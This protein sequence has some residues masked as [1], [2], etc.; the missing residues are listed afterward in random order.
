MRETP[1]QECRYRKSVCMW[2][3]IVA[4]CATTATAKSDVQVIVHESVDPQALSVN[5]VRAIFGMRLRA[6]PD[7]QPTQVFV[8]Y[9]QHPLHVAFSKEVLNIFPHQ[10]R[11]AW[12][13]LVYSGTGQAPYQVG[14]EA[15]MRFLVSNT[16]GAIGYLGET[17][18]N[19]TVRVPTITQ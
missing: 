2:V 4:L 18:I 12:D 3:F 11:L 14:S 1:T 5:T 7:G 10:L 8:L 9:D 15:E 16:P 6:W 19:D 17:M 13:R